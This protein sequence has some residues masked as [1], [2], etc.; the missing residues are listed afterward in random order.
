[1]RL[2]AVRDFRCPFCLQ[3]RIFASFWRMNERCPHC[4]RP[5]ERESGYFLMSIFIGY[6]LSGVALLP[7]LG[8]A[9][10]FRPPWYVYVAVSGVALLLLSPFVFRFSR[11]LWLHLDEL[12]DPREWDEPVLPARTPPT[13]D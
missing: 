7:I 12:L 13:V 1:M 8:V 11:V 3:G 10:L 2:R 4:G 9:L 5:F 6:L